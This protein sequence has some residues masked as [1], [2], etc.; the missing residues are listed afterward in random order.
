M[1]GERELG[2]FAG[3]APEEAT[4][5]HRAAREVL[6]AGARGSVPKPY[7]IWLCHPDLV[8]ALEPLGLHLTRKSALTPR[9]IEIAVLVSARHWQAAYVLH[10][11]ARIGRRV[12]LADT[13]IDAL[14]AGEA[15]SL[16]DTRERAV[17][18]TA[19]AMHEGGP[20]RDAS[21]AR[22]KDVLP[23]TAL[24]DLAVLLGYYASV[25]FTL[26]LYA[27]PVPAPVAP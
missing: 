4:P 26:N 1:Q 27:V 10:A 17:Y 8:T 18:E 23:D 20:L 9:E 6:I 15:P 3:L 25:A 19:V 5:A 11:H 13:V 16:V 14:C 12:G 24:C 7:E 22:A 21:F 2:R